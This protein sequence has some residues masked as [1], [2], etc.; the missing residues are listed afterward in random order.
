MTSA[1]VAGR[2]ALLDRPAGDAV[3][4]RPSRP[5][6]RVSARA[7]WWAALLVAAAP[8]LAGLPFAVRPDLVG[9]ALQTAGLWLVVSAL[10]DDRPGAA[11]LLGAYA[12]FGLA[13]CIKQHDVGSRWS[14]PACSSR[15][16]GA[17]GSGS[18]SSRA[19][20]FV[21]TAIVL[22]VYLAEEWATVGRLSQAVFLAAAHVGRVHP[23]D[24]AHVEIVAISVFGKTIGLVAVLAAARLA[25]LGSRPGFVRRVVVAGGRSS[26]R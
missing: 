15:P 3:D 5:A 11:K 6:G 9:V 7:G 12:A 21:A 17:G 24:W 2:G 10:R 4:G 26:S 22:I 16:G 1:L 8:I 18:R 23:A 14:A 20:L 19:A 25:V 13:A